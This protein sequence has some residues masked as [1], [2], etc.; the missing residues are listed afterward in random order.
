MLGMPEHEHPPGGQTERADEGGSSRRGGDRASEKL[1]RPRLVLVRG[2]GAL[3]R[4][5][6]RHV[7]PDPEYEE[8]GQDY[9]LAYVRWT[10]NRNMEAYLGLIASGQVSLENLTAPPFPLE[11][12]PRAYEAFDGPHKPLIVLLRYEDGK[13]EDRRRI[14]ELDDPQNGAFNRFTTSDISSGYTE[15]WSHEVRLQSAYDGPF[16]FNVGAIMVRY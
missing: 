15:Q 2:A 4:F 6:F 3:P 1:S 16:N 7:S 13:D 11:E 10:E 9:P 12:A 5:G 14:N 8:G